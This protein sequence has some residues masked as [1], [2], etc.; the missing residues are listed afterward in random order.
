[1]FYFLNIAGSDYESVS[2]TLTFTPNS[3]VSQVRVNLTDDS[4]SE[5]LEEFS[6]D[7]ILV[8]EML[9]RPGIVNQSLVQILD[10]ESKKKCLLSFIYNKANPHLH[11]RASSKLV[12]TG[13]LDPALS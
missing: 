11:T 6:V 1:M 4:E 12:Y 8:D 5:G 2:Q 10:N 7:I 3:T 13:T 9:G